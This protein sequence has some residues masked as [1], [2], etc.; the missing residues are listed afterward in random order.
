MNFRM[1]PQ[2][3][4]KITFSVMQGRGSAVDERLSQIKVSDSTI[5]KNLEGESFLNL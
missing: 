3:N 5:A 4:L 1:N 2:F